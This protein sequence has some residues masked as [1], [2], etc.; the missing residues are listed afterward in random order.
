MTKYEID[1]YFKDNWNEIQHVVKSNSKKCKTKN[2][3]DITTEIYLICIEKAD[4]IKTLPGFIRI[5]ASNIY[6]WSNSDFNKKNRVLVNDYNLIDTYIEDYNKDDEKYQNRL[7][8]LE[9]YKNNAN[10]I[11]QRFLE[12][13]I[14]KEI[15]TIRPLEKHLGLTRRGA[16]IMIKDFKL[17]MKEYERKAETS[18]TND[19]K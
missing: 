7:Y 12:V 1:K 17:K 15:R 8:A 16:I 19:C 11:E 18:K 10:K 5:V 4:K 9:M 2:I 6:R 14:N 13:Y 3:T